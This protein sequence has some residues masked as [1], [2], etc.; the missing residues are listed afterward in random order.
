MTASTPRID[1]LDKVA[2]ST[3]SSNITL[4]STDDRFQLVTP[5]G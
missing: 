4:V 3:P 5:L 2:I 1:K